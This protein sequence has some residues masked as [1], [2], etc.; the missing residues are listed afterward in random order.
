MSDEPGLLPS[1]MM[2]VEEGDTD[3]DTIRMARYERRL[4]KAQATFEQT[5]ALMWGRYGTGSDEDRD[6][7]WRWRH[8]FSWIHA[9]MRTYPAST[10]TPELLAGDFDPDR[11][12]DP[13]A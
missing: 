7:V 10:W 1:A 9:A 2:M 5:F 4:L 3:P 13:R 6:L 12:A 11:L 8:V